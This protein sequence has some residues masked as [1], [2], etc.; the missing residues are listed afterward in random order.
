[1]YII[2]VTVQLNVPRPPKEMYQLTDLWGVP[3]EQQMIR[4]ILQL[5]TSLFTMPTRALA[6]GEIEK[7]Q[8]QFGSINKRLK[9]TS[10]H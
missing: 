3:N 10:E 2:Y 8:S 7:H 4:N 5:L 6:I 9:E 1:M